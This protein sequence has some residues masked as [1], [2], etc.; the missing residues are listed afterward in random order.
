MVQK[1]KPRNTAVTRGRY[2]AFANTLQDILRENKELVK[3]EK[4][5]QS[6]ETLQKW[7]KRKGEIWM[8]HYVNPTKIGKTEI[9]EKSLEEVE[10]DRNLKKIEVIYNLCERLVRLEESQDNQ[11]EKINEGTA[12]NTEEN[13]MKEDGKEE[14]KELNN[15]QKKKEK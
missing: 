4:K 7:N 9:E 14:G 8:A 15:L 5:K 11:C 1:R 12:E 6:R 2:G 10:K 13:T 3:G